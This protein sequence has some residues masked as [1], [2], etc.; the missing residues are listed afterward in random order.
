M[1]S[2]VSRLLLALTILSFS[3]SPAAA[4]TSVVKTVPEYKSTLTE[5]PPSISIEF[6]DVL[7]TL[8]E[9]KV[10]SI[11][12]TS[13][14]GSSVAIESTSIDQR[15]LTVQLP[16]ESYRDGTYL[17]S[18][19]VVSADGHSISGSY[20]LYLNAPSSGAGKGVLPVEE[21][22][23]FFHLHKGHIIQAGVALIF[24]ALWWGY[25]RFTREQEL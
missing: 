15:T 10:N 25:R 12:L 19:R 22:Q 14:D 13:P 9:K 17:V 24:I 11:E 18:Y 5:M 8:G 21:H 3:V 7:M 23:G 6:T 4:H 1:S 16:Q 20:E 2:K